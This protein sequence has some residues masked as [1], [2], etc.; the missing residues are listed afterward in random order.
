[1]R[2]HEV[3]DLRVVKAGQDVR[4]AGSH[5]LSGPESQFRSDE[6]TYETSFC[7]KLTAGSEPF[8]A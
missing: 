2:T 4:R 1:M 8:G 6:E 7:M 3:I 5:L